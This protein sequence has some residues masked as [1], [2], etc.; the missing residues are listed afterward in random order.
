VRPAAH[1]ERFNGSPSVLVS[2]SRALRIVGGTSADP[3]GQ[4]GDP[5]WCRR[6]LRSGPVVDLIRW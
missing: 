2:R 5:R 1:L 4:R 3:L 6:W